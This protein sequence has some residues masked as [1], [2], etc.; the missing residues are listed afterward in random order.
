MLEAQIAQIGELTIAIQED[1]AKF[2]KGNNAAG[3][4]VRKN[5][6]LLKNTSH[7]AKKTVSKVKNLAETVKATEKTQE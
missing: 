5:L 7:E 3:T 1:A 6:Q 2:L 4:R